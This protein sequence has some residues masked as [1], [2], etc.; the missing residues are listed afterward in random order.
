MDYVSRTR[1]RVRCCFE[2]KTVNMKRIFYFTGHRLRILHW[3]GKKFSGVCSFEPDSEGYSKF[4]T[5]LQSSARIAT[6]L[7]VDVIEEDFRVENIPHVYGKDKQAVIN[8]LID[9]YYRSSNQF[10]YYEIIGRE[11]TGRKDSKVLLGVLTN[12]VLIQPWLDIIDK[13]AVP[14]SGI[15]SLPV[16]SKEVLPVLGAKSG[17]VLLVSQQVSSN[18]RQTFFRDGKM[19]TSRQSVI[20]Q[21]ASNISNIGEFARPEV[22]RTTA[23]L[24]SQRLV[25]DGEVLNIHIIAS[26]EQL[27][28]VKQN[29]HARERENVVIHDVKE[30]EKKSGFEGYNSQFSDGIFAWRCINLFQAGGHYGNKNEK[31]RYLYSLASTGLYAASILFLVLG[32]LMTEAHMSDAIEY[33]KAAE[34]LVDQEKEYRQVYRNKFEAYEEV[35]ANA[36]VMNSAVDL[37]RQI[38]DHGKVSPLDLYVQLS[39]VIEKARLNDITIDTIKWK[40]E[41]V[42]EIQGKKAPVISEPKVISKDTMRH[43]AIINGRIAIPQDNYSASVDR[44][45]DI[46][47]ALKDHERVIQAEAIEMP[48]EIRSEKKF[49]AES[50]SDIDKDNINEGSFS[51]RVVMRGIDDA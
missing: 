13:C 2:R 43:S 38:K 48:V 19:I 11:N 14:L 30:L 31:E 41:Q 29:F 26:D 39:D 12:P 1:P 8:R 27:N 32:L 49:S 42:S 33:K 22:E 47:N 21:D 35:F 20:N 15:W 10:T 3:S 5:Y 18:L 17:P 46:I 4:E 36:S 16:V 28:S 50:G 7:L 9:R 37:A 45:Q 44:I 25:K 23:F 6:K 34:L 24:R 51:L 40:P